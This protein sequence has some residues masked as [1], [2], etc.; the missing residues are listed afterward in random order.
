MKTTTL[1]WLAQ[2]AW[3]EKEFKEESRKYELF[4]MKQNEFNYARSPEEA[5][6]AGGEL[7][8]MASLVESGMW[9]VRADTEGGGATL[10]LSSEEGGRQCNIMLQLRS[11]FGNCFAEGVPPCW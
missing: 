5:A 4:T 6:E 9:Y 2:K 11:E 1:K 3:D 8:E 7:L 10:Q